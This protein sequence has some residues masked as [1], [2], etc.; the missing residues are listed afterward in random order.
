MVDVQ[1]FL[2]LERGSQRTLVE[3]A[4]QSNNPHYN[5]HMTVQM[6][7]LGVDQALVLDEYV[8]TDYLSRYVSK[9]SNNIP[10]TRGGI[11][12]SKSAGNSGRNSPVPSGPVTRGRSQK[13]GR[14]IGTVPSTIGKKRSISNRQNHWLPS[15][16]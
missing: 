15:L 16:K 11:I 2:E 13:T 6:A 5:G 14:T 7:D 3:V 8:E 12:L 10:V 1:S 4:D 9:P